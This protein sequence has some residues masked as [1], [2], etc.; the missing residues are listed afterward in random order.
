[1]NSEIIPSL[2]NGRV[3]RTKPEP[4]LVVVAC[5]VENV[6]RSCG[7]PFPCGP[8]KAAETKEID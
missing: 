1:L 4:E 6:V 7:E 8:E 3:C 5:I 2:D